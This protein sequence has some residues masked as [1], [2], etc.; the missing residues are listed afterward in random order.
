M[1]AATFNGY[2]AKCLMT[3][4]EFV[5]SSHLYGCWAKPFVITN[6]TLPNIQ[7]IA[8]DAMNQVITSTPLQ[9]PHP[10]TKERP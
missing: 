9:R 4:N 1:Q 5:P 8:V 7:P 2:E 3:P 6:W 10:I